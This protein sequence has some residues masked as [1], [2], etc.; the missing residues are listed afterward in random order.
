MISMIERA[1]QLRPIIEQAIAGVDDKLAS[2]GVELSPSL[3]EDG[4]LVKSGTRVN[5]HGVLKRAA[6]D[7]W[8]TKENNPDNSP[9]LWETIMY[10]DGIRIIPST[11]TAGTAFSKG[12][13]GWWDYVLY[14]S[15][16][17]ANVWT[18][19]AYPAGWEK[20]GE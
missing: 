8:D 7:L 6:V 19:L 16:I 17:D 12:E 1:Y 15:L 4:S 20:K 2:E 3:K 10:K 18:P 5:W 14:E 9:N 13:L 11:I